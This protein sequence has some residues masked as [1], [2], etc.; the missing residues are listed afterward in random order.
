MN[1]TF[2][3]IG[4]GYAGLATG[5]K[6]IE[7]GYKVII[8]EEKEYEGGLCYT[9]NNEDFLFDIGGHRLYT[10]SLIVFE[11]LNNLLGKDSFLERERISRIYLNKR[12]FQY[13]LKLSDVILNQKISTIIRVIKDFI[14]INLRSFLFPKREK[15]DPENFENWIVN[16]FGRT[17]YNIFFKEY[18]EKVWKEDPQNLHQELA[19]RRVSFTSIKQVIAKLLGFGKK[20]TPRTYIT[21]LYYPKY[22]IGTIAKKMKD[23]FVNRGGII[24]FNTTV[25]KF[26]GKAINK[27]DQ[28]ICTREDKEF[29]LEIDYVL[30]T[31]PLPS[32]LRLMNNSNMLKLE[33]SVIKQLKYKGIICLYLKIDTVLSFSD[34]WMYIPEKKYIIFRIVNFTNWSPYMSPKG[35]TSLCLEISIDSVNIDYKSIYNKAIEDMEELGLLKRQNIIGHFFKHFPFAYPIYLTNYRS[36]LQTIDQSLEKYNNL[37]TFGRQG[38]FNYTTMDNTLRIGFEVADHVDRCVQ[39]SEANIY[40]EKFS[41]LNNKFQEE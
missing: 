20:E 28:V 30:S 38:A 40:D 35:C 15:Q 1:K 37:L 7:K 29:S 39:N 19:V 2:L 6:L 4:A 32:L 33:E 9:F 18:T 23:N 41:L 8:I 27:I 16:R 17:L 26:E 34:T 3:I 31:I 5:Y 12:F 22:G 10:K 25:I 13:P 11:F 21:D 14:I 24:H 36:V